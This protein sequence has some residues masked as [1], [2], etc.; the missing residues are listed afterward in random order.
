M[1]IYDLISCDNR[2][3]FVTI[4]NAVLTEGWELKGETF[5]RGADL[6]QAVTK[7]KPSEEELQ[8]YHGFSNTSGNMPMIVGAIASGPNIGKS[9]YVSPDGTVGFSTP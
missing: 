7:Y 5:I 4:V 2:E 6:C 1:I 3:D 9:V 8:M